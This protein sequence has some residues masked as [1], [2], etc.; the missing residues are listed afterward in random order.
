M[1]KLARMVLKARRGIK[2]SKEK[3]ARGANE[4]LK[5]RKANGV[6]EV[7]EEVSVRLEKASRDL[8]AIRV[9]MGKTGMTV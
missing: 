9:P 3:K 5:A 1:E 4:V 6:Y 8:R 2:A 7:K